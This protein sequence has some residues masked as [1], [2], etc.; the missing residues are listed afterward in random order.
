MVALGAVRTGVRLGN[1]YIFDYYR[2]ALRTI[3][4]EGLLSFLRRTSTPYLTRASS[5][6]DPRSST[7]S[8][9]L[10]RRWAERR[11]PVGR[12]TTAQTEASDEENAARS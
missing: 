4:E 12:K 9:R 5:H 2:H 10:L 8:E 1:V 11:S 3:V 7:Y 6:F